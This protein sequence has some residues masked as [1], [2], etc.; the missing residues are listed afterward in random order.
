MPAVNL[1]KFWAKNEYS[2]WIPYCTDAQQ[3]KD[4]MYVS[5]YARS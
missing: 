2:K 1:D 5:R 4:V 3:T